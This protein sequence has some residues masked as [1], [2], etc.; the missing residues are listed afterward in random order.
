LHIKIGVSHSVG[1]MMKPEVIT[2]TQ[3]S[4]Y[5]NSTFYS[6]TVHCAW[7]HFCTD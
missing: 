5:S 7:H 6:V 4:A 3:C 2:L 1:Q